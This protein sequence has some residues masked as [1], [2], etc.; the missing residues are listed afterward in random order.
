MV[1][2]ALFQYAVAGLKYLAG[3]SGRVPAHRIAESMHVSIDFLA[4][5]LQTLAEAGIVHSYRGRTGGFRLALSPDEINL[6]A[7]CEAIDGV[8]EPPAF[9]SACDPILKAHYQV[10]CQAH[11]AALAGLTLADLL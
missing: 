2:S 6:L 7:V 1:P 10:L 4:K 9:I 8:V 5:P 3:S 11:R